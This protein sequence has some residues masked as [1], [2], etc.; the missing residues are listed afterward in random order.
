VA[1]LS[2]DEVARDVAGA[3][4]GVAAGGVVG[5]AIDAAGKQKGG[6]LLGGL[7]L[8]LLIGA[9]LGGAGES[10]RVFTLAYD[11]AADQWIAYDGGLLQ[12]MKDQLAVN[13]R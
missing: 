12:W 4:G 11:P 5:A 7:V 3:V 1:R 2:K 8:G 9:P 13:A 6:G 10:R